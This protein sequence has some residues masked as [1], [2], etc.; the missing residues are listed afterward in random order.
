MASV[1]ANSDA[2]LAANAMLS[3]T[4]YDRDDDSDIK[5]NG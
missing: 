5:G 4:D 3:M 2:H 1:A